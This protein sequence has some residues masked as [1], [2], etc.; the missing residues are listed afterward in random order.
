MKTKSSTGKFNNTVVVF[1]VESFDSKKWVPKQKLQESPLTE[2][3]VRNKGG[4]S[5]NK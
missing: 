5:I 1:E 4:P 3:Y 2:S